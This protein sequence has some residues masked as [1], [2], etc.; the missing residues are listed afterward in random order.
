MLSPWLTDLRKVPMLPLSLA[1]A[2]GVLLALHLDLRVLP[3]M[4]TCAVALVVAAVF[5]FASKRAWLGFAA[6]IFFLIVL[7][8]Y[9]AT[10]NL[11]REMRR[12]VAEMVTEADEIT[13][14]GRVYLPASDAPRSNRV[15]LSQCSFSTDTSVLNT[16]SFR[17]RLYADSTQLALLKSGDVVAAR[18]RLVS[19]RELFGTAGAVVSSLV[20]REIAAV[21]VDSVSFCAVPTKGSVL[22]RS[23]DRF[24]DY[25]R[26]AFREHLSPDGAALCSALVLGDRGDFGEE[27]TKDLR[28]TGLSHI[29]ALSGM[30]TG[31]IALL[32]WLGLS[33]LP[34]PHSAKL[35]LLLGAVLMYMEIGREAPSL[36]R[37]SLVAVMYLVGQLMHRHSVFLNLVLAAAFVE[38]LWKPLDLADPGFL[39]SYLAVLGL[40]GGYRFVRTSALSV[41]K[42]HPHPL[43]KA[44]IGVLAGT[45][46]AQIAT[47]PLVAHLFHRIPLLGVLGN[48]IA[49]PGFALMLILAIILLLFSAVIPFAVSLLAPALNLIAWVLGGA[50]RLSADLPWASMV[51]PSFGTIMWISLS[52][53]AGLLLLGMGYRQWRWIGLAVLLTGNVVVWQ[54][55]FNSHPPDCRIIFIDV[56]NGDA[57][58]ISAGDHHVLVDAGP[59]FGEWSAAGRIKT[60]LRDRNIEQLDA[61]ILTHP[62][63]DHIGGTAEIVAALPVRHVFT[64]GESSLSRTWVETEI[65]LKHAELTPEILRAGDVIQLSEKASLTVL[66]PGGE[67]IADEVFDNRKSVVMRLQSGSASALLPADADS[68]VEAHL[69]EW[70]RLADVDLLK[71]A[72]HGAKSSTSCALLDASSP[73]VCLISAGK[74]NLFNH[75]SP[76]VLERVGRHNIPIL[77]TSKQGHIEFVS[78]E[79]GWKRVESDV[80]GLIRRWKLAV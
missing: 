61:L 7:G 41:L 64:N 25:A 19:G 45:V 39:L 65:A 31:F 43:V 21:Y 40:I 20:R 2:A 1:V 70:G 75:P 23:V 42:L 32:I 66:S 16:G 67:L 24:R 71:C 5:L 12:A 72:H 56:E 14:I 4:W 74:R 73:D 28:L 9:R 49:I 47:L 8:A 76:D 15:I 69:I 60:V 29:F 6:V 3:L 68:V 77:I 79:R 59:R 37:A 36:V 55:A 34:I 57:T 18:G 52:I 58:L 27:F 13:V 78:S 26:S 38:L 46:A 44:L 50:V 30:N 11:G 22:R 80:D 63:N 33:W 62:D 54:G 51:V 10:A 48:L 17:I 35:W 53:S